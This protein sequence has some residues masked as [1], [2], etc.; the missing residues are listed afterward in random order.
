[1]RNIPDII[2]EE[3]N[4]TA[5]HKG[6]CPRCPSN[7]AVFPKPDPESEDYASLPEGI[8]QQYVFPCAWRPSKL[9]KGVCEQLDYYE[10]IHK[11]LINDDR[12]L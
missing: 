8:K 3:K 6:Y 1:M 11:H 7:R 9:C 5:V 4:I 10:E 12:K 2:L